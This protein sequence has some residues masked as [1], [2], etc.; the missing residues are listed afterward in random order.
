MLSRDDLTD[1]GVHTVGHRLKIL[2]GVA[3]LGAEEAPQQL[4]QQQQAAAAVE[5]ATTA[6]R[7]LRFDG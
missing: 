2:R 5:G 6:V 3:D 4:Q 1:I 7:E